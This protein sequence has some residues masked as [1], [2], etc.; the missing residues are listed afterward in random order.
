M[1]ESELSPR[2][3]MLWVE[4]RSRAKRSKE[5]NEIRRRQGRRQRIEDQKRGKFCDTASSI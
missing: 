5:A 1:K 2:S 4:W 3:L